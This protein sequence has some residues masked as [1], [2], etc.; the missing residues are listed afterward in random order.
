[1]A[2]VEVLRTLFYII[3]Q[4]PL[5]GILLGVA[6]LGVARILAI[7]TNLQ[8]QNES[9]QKELTKLKVESPGSAEATTSPEDMNKAVKV[10]VEK[11]KAKNT[12]ANT[13]REALN[14]AIWEAVKHLKDVR[15]RITRLVDQNKT[16]QD[17]LVKLKASKPETK[18]LQTDGL[19][20]GPCEEYEQDCSSK[21]WGSMR[22]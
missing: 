5:T 18:L 14:K 12:T 15:K 8:K 20:L 11:L 4:N 21:E 7:I 9:L 17:E 22:R 1:M 6:W 13:S 19:V 3:R 10:E 16:L 2:E